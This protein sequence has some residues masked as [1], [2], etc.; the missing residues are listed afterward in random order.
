MC[1]AA[2]SVQ[3]SA[4]ISALAVT[5]DGEIMAGT[6]DGF[7]RRYTVLEGKV[8]EVERLDLKGKLPLDLVVGTLPGSEAPVLIMGLTDR[9]VQVWT[10]DNASVSSVGRNTAD[11]STRMP[12]R[13]RDTR[14]GSAASR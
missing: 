11:L 8:T 2:F 14:T 7:V 12:S 6:S 3:K 10:L 13:W 1:T 4:S 5:P 9:K